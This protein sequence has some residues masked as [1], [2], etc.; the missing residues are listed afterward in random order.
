MQLHPFF[1]SSISDKSPKRLSPS[2]SIVSSFPVYDLQITAYL[3]SFFISEEE[4]LN[5]SA[6]FNSGIAMLV[7][8]KVSR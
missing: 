6:F 8:T 1:K 7:A 4:S 2:K 5:L 3:G